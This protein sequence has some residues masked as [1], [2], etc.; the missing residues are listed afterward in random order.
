MRISKA[1]SRFDP[2]PIAAASLGQV[3][4][5]ALRD[6]REVVVKVQR[7]GI[8]EQIV[9]DFEVLARD[10]GVPREAHRVAAAPRLAARCSRSC[11]SRSAH[12]LDYEREAQNLIARG[13]RTCSASS[14]SYVPQPIADFCTRRVL[15][16]EYVPRDQDHGVEPDGA[17]RDG[18]ARAR[19]RALP[20]PT[21]SRSWSTASSMPTRTRATCSSREDSHIALLDLG[22]VGRTTPA[23]QESLLKI[24][25]AVSEGKGEQAADGDGPDE[26]D[27]RGLRSQYRFERRVAQLVAEQQGRTAADQRRRDAPR[28]DRHRRRRGASTCRA[29][30]RCSA[31]RCCSWTRS[32]RPRSRIRSE[33]RDPAPRRDDHVASACARHATPGNVLAS[34][35]R[36][37]GFRLGTAGARQPHHGRG[38]QQGARGEGARDRRA[39]S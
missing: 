17:P 16:M 19:R 7:P 35:A 4:R 23:M 13:R 2:E 11:A 18:R 6:G 29:S 33:R 9:D 15:T 8:T 28:S 20:A 14:A 39:A 32:A 26:R 27:R 3:H 5:A 38:R 24:L 37:E 25:I 22:M 36:D 31:R 10:R 21:C 12:E 1:F 30:S 34:A